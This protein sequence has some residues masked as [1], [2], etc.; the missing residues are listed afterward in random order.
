MHMYTVVE[1]RARKRNTQRFIDQLIMMVQCFDERAGSDY[2]THI[3][4]WT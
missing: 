2:G 1:N 3:L 4:K